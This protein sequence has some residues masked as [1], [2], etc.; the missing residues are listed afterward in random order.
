MERKDFC[1]NCRKNT[2][3]TLKK[4]DIIK[5]IRDKEYTF[6]ITVAICDECGK[7]MSILGL[8][9]QNVQE[10]DEEFRAYEDI[11]SILDIEKL[12][13]IYTI[14]KAPLS[15]VLG[16]GEI[17]ITRYLAGQM[18][19]K[20]YSD[21]IKNALIS[22]K[23]MKKKLE[24]NRNKIAS[25]AYNKAMKS[26][27]EMEKMFTVSD[28]ML[29]TISFIFAE[30]E[31]VT[32]L[33]LQKLLYFIQGISFS[34]NKRPMFP[35]DCQAWIHGPVYLEVY[36]LFRDFKYNPID[37]SRFVIFQKRKNNL[38][39]EDHRVIQLVMDTF[40]QC[41]PKELE[42]ITHHEEPWI[43]SR[44]GYGDNIVS[45]TVIEQEKICSYFTKM[46]LKYDF[47]SEK[48]LQQYIKDYS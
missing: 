47:S 46:G 42:R 37:D 20:E 8:M 3:Y 25:S 11:V 17:T 16:F 30:L 22:P 24:E 2:E 27:I 40:G 7:E 6:H 14:G 10:I 28:S 48:G 29:K 9:D 41:S 36:N 23:Y 5:M 4:K 21:V 15:L 44:K 34:L 13:E 35:E 39:E 32:P 1:L 18:P 26:V 43:L 12:M 19:S 31:E 38:S 45:N 33:M